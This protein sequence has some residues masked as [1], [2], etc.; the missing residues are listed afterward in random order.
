MNSSLK[1]KDM[2]M[3]LNYICTEQFVKILVQSLTNCKSYA[4]LYNGVSSFTEHVEK[5]FATFLL[6]GG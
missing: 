4:D 3:L 5:Y 2:F 6:R 1:Y